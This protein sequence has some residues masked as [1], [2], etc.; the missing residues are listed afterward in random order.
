MVSEPTGSGSEIEE[1]AQ[2]SSCMTTDDADGSSFSY[3]HESNGIL[4]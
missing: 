1:E 3:I 2:S 4:K